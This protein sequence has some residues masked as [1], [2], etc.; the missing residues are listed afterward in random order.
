LPC[1][2]ILDDRQSEAVVF[3]VSDGPTE[4]VERVYREGV[5]R[6]DYRIGRQQP[7]ASPLWPVAHSANGPQKFGNLEAKIP[8]TDGKLGCR[9]QLLGGVSEFLKI[10]EIDIEL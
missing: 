9:L 6:D 2:R 1:R 7:Q 8:S 4:R 5:L 3:H 10:H